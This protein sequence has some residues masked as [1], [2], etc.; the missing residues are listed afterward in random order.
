M[1]KK[2]RELGLPCLHQLTHGDEHFFNG[3]TMT[4]TLPWK[5]TASV[6][7][8]LECD[9]FFPLEVCVHWGMSCSLPGVYTLSL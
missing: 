6:G 9:N 5:K 1:E 8:L 3:V 2:R 4:L 7:S